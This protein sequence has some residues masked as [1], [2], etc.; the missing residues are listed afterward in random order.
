MFKNRS[1]GLV[2]AAVVLWGA[3]AF[4]AEPPPVS[5]TP[6]QI[7]EVAIPSV[8]LIQTATGLGSGFVVSKDGRIATN[9][10]VISGSRTA[11]VIL[12][13]RRKFSEV[14][15]LAG[16]AKHDLAVL[17]IRAP[18]LKPLILGDSNQ[19]KPG[20]R[21]VAIGHPLGL[22]NTVSDGLVSA[23]REL[24][25]TLSVLQISAPISPGSSGG[26]ILNDRAQVI[27]ISTLVVTEG[28]N[29]AFGM[30]VNQLRTLLDS[31]GPGTPIASWSPPSANDRKVPKHDLALLSGC[32]AAEQQE[33]ERR[34]EAA[35]SSGAP[36]YN[37]GH[38]EAC[39]RIYSGAA[40][41]IDRKVRGCEAVRQALLDGIR[42]SDTIDNYTKKAWA[43]RD[44]FDG[45]LDAISRGHV[46][47]P[48]PPSVALP[49]APPRAVPRHPL[50]LLDGCSIAKL[51]TI[52]KGIE[53]AIESGAPLYNDGKL[54]A[55][56]RIYEGAA[57]D[58]TRK[59][60][61]CGGPK[62]ALEAG[63]REAAKRRTYGNKA[64]AMRDAF[65]GLMGVIARKLEK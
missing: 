16:D 32:P 45:V 50:S 36:V 43:M 35:I 65:D 8:V 60:Q 59:V 56:Y 23:V 24:S 11:T 57:L 39:Y 49:A 14:D 46:A 42:R 9:L 34:V 1:T 13:D 58:I 27:G 29:L 44:A 21:V 31:A 18:D 20:E 15:V 38:H 64:W 28:Q 4:A 40:L 51:L 3:A 22:G 63:L 19:V 37:E 30:P 26:P 48:E 10:H 61:G 52:A 2:A 5:L 54:E 47:A 6:A 7:A 41:E 62:G 53:G 33:I 12:S 17:Q 25:P 55:C